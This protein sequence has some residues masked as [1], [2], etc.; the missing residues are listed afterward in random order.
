MDI[1]LTMYVLFK[2]THFFIF[3]VLFLVCVLTC[4][5]THWKAVLRGNPFC[6]NIHA[7]ITF[8][9]TS[10]TEP[11]LEIYQDEFQQVSLKLSSRFSRLWSSK[12]F[13]MPRF[14]IRMKNWRSGFKVNK[15]RQKCFILCNFLLIIAFCIHRLLWKFRIDILA[16]F[17]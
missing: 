15:V 13:T 14:K 6:R 1:Q 7:S 5:M 17:F 12:R 9:K 8:S 16:T 11:F 4:T 2:D 10:L 3:N